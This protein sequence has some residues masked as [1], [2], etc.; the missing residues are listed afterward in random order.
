VCPAREESSDPV[1]RI[2]CDALDAGQVA[3]YTCWSAAQCG[4][5]HGQD[6]KDGV[7]SPIAT[8]LKPHHI[9]YNDA[10][11]SVRDRRDD[12]RRIKPALSLPASLWPALL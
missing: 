2:H 5:G 8:P 11:P 3:S 4:S 7:Q 10:P 9:L 12:G 1:N 6:K